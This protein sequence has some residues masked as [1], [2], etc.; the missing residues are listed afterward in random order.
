MKIKLILS[1]IVLAGS[2]LSFAMAGDMV[3][4]G[5]TICPV[6]G[7]EIKG[8]EMGEPGIFD[9][10]GKRYNLCCSMCAKDFDKDPEKFSQKV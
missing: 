4:V 9:Y 2:F 10:N 8:G 7:H 3:E 1:S 6:S 5:N